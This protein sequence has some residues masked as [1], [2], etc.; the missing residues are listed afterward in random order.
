VEIG[1]YKVNGENYTITNKGGEIF[2]RMKDSA[3][4]R[5]ALGR[6]PT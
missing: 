6:L 3:S 5:A 1:L 2:R 4:K